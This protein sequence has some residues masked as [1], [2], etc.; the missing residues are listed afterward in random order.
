M[1][2]LFFSIT[3]VQN[4]FPWKLK[5][6]H[7]LTNPSSKFV[8]FFQRFPNYFVSTDGRTGDGQSYFNKR[9]IGSKTQGGNRNCDKERGKTSVNLKRSFVDSW[10]LRNCK[11]FSV[12]SHAVLRGRPCPTQTVYKCHYG[13]SYSSNK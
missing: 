9:P 10:N 2:I 8:K 11:S 7:K 13:T 3:S 12:P 4:K 1:R 6:L 5:W